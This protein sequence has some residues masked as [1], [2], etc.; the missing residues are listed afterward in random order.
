[1][2]KLFLAALESRPEFKAL[3]ERQRW[4]SAAI[5]CAES[6]LSGWEGVD[7]DA[8]VKDRKAAYGAAQEYTA[9]ALLESD[10]HHAVYSGSPSKY[11]SAAAAKRPTLVGRKAITAYYQKVL[12]QFHEFGGILPE[13]K[14]IE[15][16][17]L[18]HNRPSR[19]AMRRAKRRELNWQKRRELDLKL[20][21][22]RPNLADAL[23]TLQ[24]QETPTPSPYAPA[25]VD[26][27]IDVSAGK[28]IK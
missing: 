26:G 21:P 19:F 14:P 27:R 8:M 5:L 24:P 18:I 4:N 11:V 28:S 13:E 1:M 3:T 9:I 6:K 16:E 12:R 15:L 2:I 17:E 22:S 10:V 23:P 20:N 7:H 25:V